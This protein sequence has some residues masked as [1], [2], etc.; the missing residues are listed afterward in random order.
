[1]KKQKKLLVQIVIFMTVVLT[2]CQVFATDILSVVG[3]MEFSDEF[4]AYVNLSEEEQKTQI[5]PRTY[6]VLENEISISN[7]LKIARTAVAKS[8]NRYSLIDIIPEN[9]IVKNQGQT[10]SC[11]TFSSL[12]MLESVLALNDYKNGIEPKKYDFSER[13]MEYA[14][15][16]T[17]LNGEINKKGFNREIDEG[18]NMNLY[19]P[20]L[21]NGTGAIS[22]ASMK[23]NGDV[24]SKIALS[25]L[26]NKTVITQVDDI[27]IFPQ[28]NTVELQ[29]K[30][31]NHLKNYG[32]IDACIHGV[33]LDSDA[34][35]N[36]TGA[37]YCDDE[38]KY[39][40][41]HAVV[42]VGWDDDYSKD[43][44]NEGK[45]PNNNGAWIIK[46]SWGTAEKYT[47]EEMKQIIYMSSPEQCQQY[48]WT[49]PELIPDEDAV[50]FFSKIGFTITENNEAVF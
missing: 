48:G 10:N 34:Y 2:G 14:T 16:K 27:E 15:S 30:M 17:F 18:G 8:S 36:E 38:E 21:T 24:P 40:I 28:T 42:I 9:M 35:N 3:T 29:Q 5:M 46:N 1:M 22:E 39:P 20:Y 26:N 7:P 47:L 31:K 32:A 6:E 49:S 37:I 13:H 4:E 23:F 50:Y 11:W 45:R 12:A 33:A 41:N 44:F 43:K 19:I 25:E